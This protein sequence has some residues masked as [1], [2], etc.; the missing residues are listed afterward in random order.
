MGPKVSADLPLVHW[1][2]AFYLEGALGEVVDHAVARHMVHRLR[3]E[4]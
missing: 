1:P 2:A 4:T 3:F